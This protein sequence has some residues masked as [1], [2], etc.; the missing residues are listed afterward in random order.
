MEFGLNIP[1]T[2]PFDVVGFG[3]NAFD[4]LCIVPREA[5]RGEAGGRRFCPEMRPV[6][7]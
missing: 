5:E 2:A 7:R 4:H 3:L 6:G 1:E